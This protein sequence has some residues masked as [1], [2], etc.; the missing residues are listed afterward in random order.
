MD[1]HSTLSTFSS[2]KDEAP[3]VGLRLT[4]QG[5]LTGTVECRMRLEYL[6]VLMR[7]LSE[8]RDNVIAQ[9]PFRKAATN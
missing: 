2:S 7:Q 9:E 8:E 4:L 5:D 6:E 3:F 1:D